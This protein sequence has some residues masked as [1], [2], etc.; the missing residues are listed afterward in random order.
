MDLELGG[1][2]PKKSSEGL[3]QVETS[4]ESHAAF[5]SPDRNLRLSNHEAPREAKLAQNQDRRGKSSPGLSPR[6]WKSHLWE[7]LKTTAA[8][9]VMAVAANT[10]AGCRQSLVLSHVLV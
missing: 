8:A 9:V 7:D 6:D 5:T 2:Q 3:Q 1:G 10:L 4:H